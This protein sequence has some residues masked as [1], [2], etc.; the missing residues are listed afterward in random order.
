MVHRSCFDTLSL[1]R[2]WW[3]QS[4]RFLLL[5][6]VER[7]MQRVRYHSFFFWRGDIYPALPVLT[8][9]AFSICLR[10]SR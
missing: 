9:P 6:D 7:S 5:R 2:V 4:C 1:V 3:I 10:L 8:N